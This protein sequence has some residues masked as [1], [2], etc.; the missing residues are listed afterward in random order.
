V[1][2]ENGKRGLVADNSDC[3]ATVLG[4]DH[5]GGPADGP[6]VPLE[7]HNAITNHSKA[8]MSYTQLFKLKVETETASNIQLHA[9]QQY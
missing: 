6:R 3:Q 4:R 2:R 8:R 1:G 7:H 9:F 5:K